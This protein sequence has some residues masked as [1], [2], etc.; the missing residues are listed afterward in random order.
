MMIL[1]G[2]EVA[3]EKRA[4]PHDRHI[5]EQHVPELRQLVE[6][7]TA[8]PPAKPRDPRI[9]R[10]LE[11]PRIARVIEVCERLLLAVS[12]LSHCPKLQHS[13]PPAAEAHALL[14]K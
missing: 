10:N 12:P 14:R 4:R 5:A 11:E 8:D 13:E 9:V 1:V 2:R 6:T 7:P 3:L